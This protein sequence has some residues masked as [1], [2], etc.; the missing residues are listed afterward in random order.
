M[1]GGQGEKKTLRLM[2][3]HAEMANFTSG[4]DELPHKLEVLAGHC[5]AVGRDMATI[6][7]TSLASL[8]LGAT[9]EEAVAKIDTRLAGLGMKWADLDDTAR[10][11]FGNRFVVGDPDTVGERIRDVIAL[12]MDGICF[13]MVAD[14][15]EPEAVAFAGEVV[16]KALG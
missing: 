14:G 13:N 9:M 7:K 10:T 5:E 3:E 16:T 11:Q 12:G 15:H 6:N 8:F 1:I 2:A 4:F